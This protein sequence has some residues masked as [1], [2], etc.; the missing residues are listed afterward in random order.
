M[1]NAE[2]VCHDTVCVRSAIL[3]VQP[4]NPE[5]RLMHTNGLQ[6]KP[7]DPFMGGGAGMLH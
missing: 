4:V 2:C 7:D 1:Q 5:L 3:L 6:V